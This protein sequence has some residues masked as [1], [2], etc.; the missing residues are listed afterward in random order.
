MYYHEAIEAGAITIN[1]A[2]TTPDH[3]IQSHSK[4]GH[5]G[6][7]HEPPCTDA[8]VVILHDDEELLVVNKPGSS[9]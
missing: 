7:K 4:L 6:H 2:C 8:E 3:V 1:G 5:F 9:L